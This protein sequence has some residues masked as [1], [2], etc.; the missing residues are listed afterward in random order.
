MCGGGRVERTKVEYMDVA[1]VLEIAI[2]AAKDEQS[3]L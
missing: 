1:Q 2:G 3:R